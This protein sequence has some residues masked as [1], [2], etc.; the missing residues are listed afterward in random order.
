MTRAVTVR[1]PRLNTTRVP[2][3]SLLWGDALDVAG[4]RLPAG[5]TP[6]VEARAVPGGAVAA[7]EGHAAGLVVPPGVDLV[8][9]E[10]HAHLEGLRALLAVTEREAPALAGRRASQGAPAIAVTALED[11]LAIRETGSQRA[12][13]PRGATGAHG[14]VLVGLVGTQLR[15]DGDL[16]GVA[17][18]RRRQALAVEGRARGLSADDHAG[19]AAAPA[20]IALQAE[21][22]LV[23]ELVDVELQPLAGVAAIQQRH[24]RALVALRGTA[25]DVYRL[26]VAQAVVAH[27]EGD[28]RA[29]VGGLRGGRRGGRSEGCGSGQCPERRRGARRVVRIQPQERSS[30]GCLRG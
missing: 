28:A 15:R 4:Q 14:R 11:D 5:G 9:F 7:E 10:A 30:F 23:V 26:A 29:P 25:A 13:D 2:Q 1:L 8:P 3:G 6:A 27:L 12:P 16:D 17:G 22:A 19:L 18:A 24:R 20:V 21:A